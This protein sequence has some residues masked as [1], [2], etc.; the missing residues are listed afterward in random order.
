MRLP[1]LAAFAALTACD[2]A[3]VAHVR[4]LLP[5]GL[6]NETLF[7]SVRIEE[8]SDLRTAG[9]ILRSEGPVELA[10]SATTLGLGPLTVPHGD[11]RVAIA[12]LREGPSLDSQVIA[13]GLSEPFSIHPGDELDVPVSLFDRPPESNRVTIV[14]RTPGFVRTSTV[15]LRLTSDRGVRAQVSNF[16]QFPERATVTT[17]L[18]APINWDL[19]LGIEPRCFA[20]DACFRGVYVR[21]LDAQGY[22]SRT[23]TAAVTLDVMPPQ[24][25]PGS[26]GLRLIPDD[27][28]P[29]STVGRVRAGTTVEVSFAL[30]EPLS[31]PPSLT[32]V[33]TGDAIP[34]DRCAG[35]GL[36]WRCT[37]EFPAR[38]DLDG[39]TYLVVVEAKD[40]AG[41]RA[42]GIFAGTFVAD[43]VA[44]PVPNVDCDGCLVYHRVPFGDDAT[45]GLPSFTVTG[46][47]A[48]A[49]PGAILAILD[50][51]EEIGRSEPAAEDGAIPPIH[52]STADRDRVF[53]RALDAAGNASE[54]ALIRNVAATATFGPEPDNPNR[55]F[56]EPRFETLARDPR[57][58]AFQEATPSQRASLHLPDSELLAAPAG[59]TWR[60]V[61]LSSSGPSARE[62]QTVVWDPIRDRA[63][64]FGGVDDGGQ[65]L[66]DHWEWD[67]YNWI[68]RPPASGDPPPRTSHRMVM[69]LAR[70]AILLFGGLGGSGVLGDTWLFD[71]QSWREHVQRDG[72][73]PRSGHVMVYDP[74]REE[75]ILFGGIGAA[76]P[77]AETWSWDGTWRQRSP[78]A[79]PPPR[80]NA[81]AAFD[82][83]RNR[84]VL[85]G[86]D[87]LTGELND[88]WEWTGSTWVP[89]TPATQPSARRNPALVF[90][91]AL[92]RILM[93]GGDS[94]AHGGTEIIRGDAFTWDGSDW[95]PFD[96]SGALPGPRTRHALF[97]DP[98]RGRVYLFG[99]QAT[100]VRFGDLHGIDGDG[101]AQSLVRD[102]DPPARARAA[103]ATDP[104]TGAPLLFGGA[105]SLSG[106]S[107]WRNDLWRFEG[108]RWRAVVTSTSPPP[109]AWPSMATD[110]TRGRTVL[111][112]DDPAT[113][114]ARSFRFDGVDWA[115]LADPPPAVEGSALAYDPSLPGVLF[116]GADLYQLGDVWSPVAAPGPI[117]RSRHA[118]ASD[119]LRRAVLL[120]GG[121]DASDDVLDD[122]WRWDGAAWHA[123]ALGAPARRGHA[124]VFDPALDRL[125]VYG[126]RSVSALVLAQLA[127]WDP[128][129]DTWAAEANGPLTPR[130][131][132]G[133][134]MV[135]DPPDQATLLFG[136][137]PE[138]GCGGGAPRQDSWLLERRPADRPAVVLVA[139]LS[140]ANAARAEVQ[141]VEILARAP[142]GDLF[143]W[144]PA[145]GEWR[146]AS[147][148][149]ELRVAARDHDWIDGNLEV[150][151]AVAGATAA[152]LDYAEITIEYR[153]DGSITD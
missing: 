6:P 89:T 131:R 20:S 44:P 134:A 132:E 95:T 14:T 144:R 85:F 147:T 21:F 36:S 102:A 81:G 106:L 99:G 26:A 59:F 86:G 114:A 53:A 74:Q 133:H 105:A 22:A 153:L 64:L 118:L 121:L 112:G 111:V 88:T 137:C 90:H 5:A 129:T 54:P 56:L 68:L 125:L 11:R 7:V 27:A 119:P 148:G 130:G 122:L 15:E 101:V 30:S 109:L 41:N 57:D 80:F 124:M 136:G 117:G 83:T 72:P 28:N 46:S 140:A 62:N 47:A 150:H 120:F 141:R 77:L 60:D 97:L 65:P 8:R 71:G 39:R 113:G 110:P 104:T 63:L 94:G 32:A 151:A 69:D 75:V 91:P 115:P 45:A 19:E 142:E 61:T 40:L 37:L 108:T 18:D 66:G 35:F 78:A 82:P 2:P 49:E 123:A 84:I 103:L 149:G 48:A 143:L 127:S 23:A 79:V 76:G 42:F 16:V 135:Y 73:S 87:S 3:G 70:S 100:G 51:A 12:E 9:P 25:L 10:P 43:T 13:Y 98:G 96:L 50:G 107:D 33:G 146:R 67:R 116:F 128:A 29:L 138:V 152:R 52:L 24:L 92:G 1:V 38:P 58:G 126:G 139:R 55:V 17:D 31:A 145:T 93:L 34:F 4:F